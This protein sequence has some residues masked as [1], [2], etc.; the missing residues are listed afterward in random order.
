MII[1][2]VIITHMM[3]NIAQLVGSYSLPGSKSVAIFENFGYIGQVTGISIIN[4]ERC[5]TGAS[6]TSAIQE[7]SP[8]FP[9][10]APVLS[11]RFVDSNLIVVGEM[12]MVLLFSVD[13]I[14]GLLSFL[15]SSMTGSGSCSDIAVL[16]S[17]PRTLVLV[18][19]GSE[20]IR[21]FD[22]SGQRLQ[23]HASFTSTVNIS[24]ITCDTQHV[25]GCVTAGAITLLFNNDFNNPVFTTVELMTLQHGICNEV[26]IGNNRVFFV[27]DALMEGF[28]RSGS[29]LV[30]RREVQLNGGSPRLGRAVAVGSIFLV[31]DTYFGAR[32]IDVSGGGQLLSSWEKP[33]TNPTISDIAY[34][35]GYLF[36]ADNELGLFVLQ[37]DGTP[38]PSLVPTLVPTAIPTLVPTAIPTRPPTEAPTL[39]P[40]D[41]PLSRAPTVVPTLVPNT[42]AP[43]AVPTS[44][45]TTAPTAVPTSVPTTAPTAVPTSVP[46]TA[47]TAVPTSVPTAAP[48]PATVV[49]TAV[50]TVVPTVVPTA[51]PT[52]DVPTTAPTAAPAVVPTVVPTTP[53]PSTVSTGAP[54]TSVPTAVPT[55]VPTTSFPTAYP[56]SSPVASVV[57][58]GLPTATPTLVPTAI[59]ITSSTSIP[60]LP[61]NVPTGVPTLLQTASPMASPAVSASPTVN[62]ITTSPTV[63]TSAPVTNIPTVMPSLP[64]SATIVPKVVITLI[65]STAAPN[66]SIP[67]MN[68]TIPTPVPTRP[69]SDSALTKG[70]EKAVIA[71]TG[72]AV[73]MAVV[74]GGGAAGSATRLLVI[75]RRCNFYSMNDYPRLLHPTGWTIGNSSEVGMVVGNCII[76][77]SVCFACIVSIQLLKT[78]TCLGID[79]VKGFIRYPSVPIQAFNFLF[80][81]TTLGALTLISNPTSEYD[82]ILGGFSV[83]GCLLVPTILLLMLKRHVPRMVVY[84]SDERRVHKPIT[85]WFIG[86]GEWVSLTTGKQ[87]ARR[88]RALLHPY[89]E[90]CVLYF[91]FEVA[92]SLAIS[93]VQSIRTPNIRSCGYV[94]SAEAFIFL[95]LVC[96]QVRV[97]PYSR[98]RD[99][100]LHSIAGT[101]QCMAMLSAAIGHYQGYSEDELNWNL[102]GSL[103]T[104]SIGAVLLSSFLDLSSEIYV[105]VKG[106]RERLQNHQWSELR[107]VPFNREA[108]EMTVRLIPPDSNS[109][110]D[111]DLTVLRQESEIVVSIDQDD[112]TCHS[113]IAAFQASPT[114][115]VIKPQRPPVKT[116][117]RGTPVSSR[118]SSISSMPGSPRRFF[119]SI[120]EKK[121][122]SDCS[123]NSSPTNILRPASVMSGFGSRHTSVCDASPPASRSSSLGFP[124]FDLPIQFQKSRGRTRTPDPDGKTSPLPYFDNRRRSLSANV[125]NV[126]HLEAPP[127]MRRRRPSSTSVA[128]S[129]K[130]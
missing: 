116:R 22:V 110:Y 104:A 120:A 4:W 123:G 130:V 87:F 71:A 88:F 89:K 84:K 45:P 44:V 59:P 91:I 101:L 94:R 90:R 98:P 95:L 30:N 85:K 16:S 49:P 61:T 7:V 114:I 8:P 57:P 86:K 115:K 41:V 72:I 79:D 74:S 53:T 48:T 111:D 124:T 125:P 58:T 1:L 67:F 81:G 82:V 11:V 10:L 127:F 47:S 119:S 33:N 109:P 78:C 113:G 37:R 65:P 17:P 118:G 129:T 121:R 102:I 3:V 15:D 19:C 25:Y 14:S 77:S 12:G 64:P 107:S 23:Q 108:S 24:H 93:A 38:V 18:T 52:T 35:D 69:D 76:S 70:Q 13:P 75:S 96:Y 26:L 29:Q 126:Q 99:A 20:G 28:Q 103:L 56:T 40:T 43:T 36:V 50:P 100:F 60:S 63:P 68:T 97:L 51:A 27:Q 92:A 6:V 106:D 21:V 46:T 5:K 73:G 66:T 39:V 105:L 2:V 128:R 83:A 62:L 80:Q 54:P 42:I 112:R 55:A 122:F 31:T 32:E 34:S 117:R 9:T